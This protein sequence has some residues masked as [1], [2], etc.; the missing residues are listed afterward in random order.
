MAD[1]PS[2][3]YDPRRSTFT[4]LSGNQLDR[5]DDG[6]PRIR[7]FY[8]VEQFDLTILHPLITTAE[9]DQ[10][11]SFYDT[12]RGQYVTFNRV[13]DSQQYSVLMIERPTDKHI[14]GGLWDVSVRMTGPLL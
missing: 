4:P 12:Y 2:I 7:S 10:I 3:G 1:Y 5:A 9:R 11:M 14:S 8:P 13:S 6:T